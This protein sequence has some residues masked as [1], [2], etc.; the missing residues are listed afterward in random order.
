MYA[1]RSYYAIAVTS[2][3]DLRST[4]DTFYKAFEARGLAD[5][6]KRVIAV[7]VQPG[8]EFADNTII[9]Y[10]AK[11]AEELIRYAKSLEGIVLEGHSTDYQP[12]AA[13]DLMRRDGIAILKVGPALTFAL[14]NNFV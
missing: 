8:V 4:L 1:I 10:D 13:L 9:K 7:V 12:K 14:R 11:M 2:P 6:W 3:E 5:A